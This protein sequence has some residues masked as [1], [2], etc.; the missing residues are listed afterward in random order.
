MFLVLFLIMPTC[1]IPCFGIFQ[2]QKSLEEAP[3]DI[4][5]EKLSTPNRNYKELNESL[6]N[7][8][9][10]LGILSL[11]P[12][13]DLILYFFVFAIAAVLTTA[14]YQLYSGI[15]YI[16]DERQNIIAEINMCTRFYVQKCLDSEDLRIFLLKFISVVLL[17]SSLLGACI[18]SAMF[19]FCVGLFILG[20]FFY[21]LHQKLSE[22]EALN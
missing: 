15:K 13:I 20:I 9:N 17:L 22:G 4:E 21:D 5:L 10:D 18:G 16:F 12:D 2:Y 8:I 7:N 11:N 14:L 1:I 19:G 6:I 3:M